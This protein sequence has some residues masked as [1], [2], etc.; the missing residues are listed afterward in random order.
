MWLPGGPV[1]PQGRAE[2]GREPCTPPLPGETPRRKLAPRWPPFWSRHA[3]VTRPR[4]TQPPYASVSSPELGVRTRTPPRP[5]P[6][7]GGDPPPRPARAPRRGPS[8]RNPCCGRSA[9]PWP[10]PQEAGPPAGEPRLESDPQ[11]TMGGPPKGCGPGPDLP[12]SPAFPDPTAQPPP[13]ETQPAVP[14]WRVACG[15]WRSSGA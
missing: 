11:E 10:A 14:V 4:V 8:S 2:P 5:C 15:V 9:T 7:A 1:S 6:A 13:P 3:S 12:G